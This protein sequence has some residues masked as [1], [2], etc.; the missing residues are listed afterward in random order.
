MLSNVLEIHRMIGWGAGVEPT[1]KDGLALALG[2]GRGRS[3][4]TP[5]YADCLA[6]QLCEAQPDPWQPIGM[7]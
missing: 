2:G 5:T 3:V 6:R 7:R 4:W 1:H